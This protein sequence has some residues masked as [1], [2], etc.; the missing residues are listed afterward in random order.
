MGLDMYFSKRTYVKRWNHNPEE[1]QYR[2]TV[3]RGG[4][5]VPKRVISSDRIS[6]VIEEVAYWRKANHTHQWFVNNVQQGEDDCKEYYVSDDDLKKLV[7]TCKEVIAKAKLVDGKLHNGTTFSAAGRE[8][9]YVDGKVIENVEEIAGLLPT[10]KGFFFGSTDYN[11]WYLQ[12][13][14]DTIDQLEP[15]IKLMDDPE[16]KYTGEYYYQSSW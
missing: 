5:V 4:K 11:E 16:W 6:Y 2:V 14:Q 13:C 12:D 10:S 1:K 7:E 15:E 8:E 9:I 3:R